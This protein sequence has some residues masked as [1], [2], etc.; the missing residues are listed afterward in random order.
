[1]LLALTAAAALS[2]SAQQPAAG[3]QHGDMQGMQRMKCMQSGKM[4]HGDMGPMMQDCHKT[5]Q[6]MMEAN[7]K[8]KEDIEAAKA[9]NDPAKMRAALDEAGKAL[10]AMTSHMQH[11]AGMMGKMHDMP[12]TAGEQQSKPEPQK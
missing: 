6:S 12:G 2:L 10:D 7:S 3:D 9:S 5:M 11:C 8:A 1:M 4:Q